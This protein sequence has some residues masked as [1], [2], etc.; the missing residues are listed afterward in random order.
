MKREPGEFFVPLRRHYALSDRF[1][2]ETVARTLIQDNG[3]YVATLELF[4]CGSNGRPYSSN[5]AMALIRDAL[6]YC[7]TDLSQ[8]Q[9]DRLAQSTVE[10]VLRKTNLNPPKPVGLLARDTHRDAR[11]AAVKAGR[12]FRAGLPRSA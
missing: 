8:V 5:D 10:F 11:K 2:F 3:F 4:R 1:V 6:R 12:K 9:M 7:R